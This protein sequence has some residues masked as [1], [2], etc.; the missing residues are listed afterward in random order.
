MEKEVYKTT[1]K[2]D[3]MFFDVYE[4]IAP[5]G[6]VLIEEDGELV[7]KQSYSKQEEERQVGYN[8]VLARYEEFVSERN[9]ATDLRNEKIDSID[10]LN[11]EIE[12]IDSEIEEDEDQIKYYEVNLINEE[13]VIEEAEEVE[14]DE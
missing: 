3:D 8:I 6:E 4:I 12:Q 5:L 1:V 11:K 14:E 2:R 7:S 13:D 9:D 10:A